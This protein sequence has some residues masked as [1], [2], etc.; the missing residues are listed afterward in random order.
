[1]GQYHKLVNLDKR[2]FV[3]PHQLGDGLKAWEQFASGPGGIGS[4]MILLTVCPDPR[5]GGDLPEGPFMGRWHGDRVLLVGD[6]AESDD[7]DF[8]TDPSL[9]YQLTS[10]DQVI[11]GLSAEAVETLRFTDIT[12]G[13]RKVMA[14][15]LDWLS[16]DEDG[17]GWIAR[18]EHSTE[19]TSIDNT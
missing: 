11:K 1:M 2:E 19:T 5:G 9:I 10:D 14:E 8:D 17:E 6:Y 7:F 15:S 4:A 18:S 12:V 13:V 3:H 16:Y